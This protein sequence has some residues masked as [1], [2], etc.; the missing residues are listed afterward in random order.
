MSTA[1]IYDYESIEEYL[2]NRLRTADNLDYHSDEFFPV[3]L[4][5]MLFH[6]SE[7]LSIVENRHDKGSFKNFHGHDFDR[8]IDNLVASATLTIEDDENEASEIKLID[9]DSIRINPDGDTTVM[10][11][12]ETVY[13]VINI[14]DGISRQKVSINS[15]QQLDISLDLKNIISQAANNEDEEEYQAFGSLAHV[16]RVVCEKNSINP[17]EIDGRRL[18][19]KIFE[20]FK[21]ELLPLIPSLWNDMEIIY[22]TVTPVLTYCSKLC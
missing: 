12:D 10:L 22:D 14:T 6:F 15:V 8:W 1:S 5:D 19:E 18:S 17:A 20:I 16:V 7:K 3:S 4:L 11:P 2:G 9:I 21:F 13:N